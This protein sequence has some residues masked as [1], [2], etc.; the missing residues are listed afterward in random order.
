MPEAPNNAASAQPTTPEPQAPSLTPEQAQILLRADDRNRLQRLRAGG[1]LSTAERN[2]LLAIATGGSPTRANF[3]QNQVQLAEVIGCNRKTIQRALKREGNPGT[4]PDGRYDVNAW[5]EFFRQ[6]GRDMDGD[7]DARSGLGALREENLKLQ[8]EKLK[9]TLEILD[10][11]YT[12]TNSVEEWGAE[13]GAA[14]RKIVS[15]IHLSAPTIIECQT[16]AEVEAELKKVEDD[17][18]EQLHTLDARMQEWRNEPVA[19]GV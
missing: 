8:N 15:Q 17:I 12:P 16:V 2:H 5:R 13:L 19:E 18:I 9:R 7:D 11:E 14:V 4:C 6:R 3:V 1:R 10:K